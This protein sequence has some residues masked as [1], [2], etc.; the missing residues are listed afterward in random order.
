MTASKKVQYLNYTVYKADRSSTSAANNFY[1]HQAKIVKSGKNYHLFLTVKAKRGLVK[2]QPLSMQLGP[3]ISQ[4]HYQKGGKDVWIYGVKFAS[5][6]ALKKKA[7]LRCGS[8]CQLLILSSGY[9]VS[10]LNLA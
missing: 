9:S 1:T 8:V 6:T 4:R 5:L 7:L 2:F 10:G 3:I